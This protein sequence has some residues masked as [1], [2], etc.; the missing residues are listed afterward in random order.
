V[1]SEEPG[2]VTDIR[3]FTTLLYVILRHESSEWL[4]SSIESDLGMRLA[5]IWS[6][7][8]AFHD[9]ALFKHSF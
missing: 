7:N 6:L 2:L 3:G 5:I 8:L 1:T 4:A 9:F